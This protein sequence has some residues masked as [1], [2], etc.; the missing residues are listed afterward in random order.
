MRPLLWRGSNTPRSR[1]PSPHGAACPSA[2]AGISAATIAVT[3]AALFLMLES[4]RRNTSGLVRDRSDRILASVVERIRMHLEPARDQSYFLARMVADGMFNPGDETSSVGHLSAALAGTPQVATLAIIRTD[5]RQL[6]VERQGN[7]IVTRS[8]SMR[9]VPG[10]HEAFE[11]AR[12]AGQSLWGELLW[13]ERLNQ[14]LVNIR[15]P[16]WHANNFVVS[17]WL[18]SRSRSCRPLWCMCRPLQALRQSSCMDV[19]SSSL[20]RL[21]HALPRCSS[22]TTLSRSSPSWVTRFSH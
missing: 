21:S 13:S 22:R 4:G 6:L 17:C 8:I 10:L 5:L 14:P 18:V 9:T 16:L 11:D 15:T 3:A 20:T 2:L 7:T 12:L 1:G 19:G